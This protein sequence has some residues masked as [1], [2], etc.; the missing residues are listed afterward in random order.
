MS[1][2]ADTRPRRLVLKL[3]TRHDAEVALDLAVALAA[4]LHSEL[5]ALFL[6]EE[7]SIT[8]GMLP[9]PT[10]VDF[11]G[12]TLPS[13]RARIETA[14][15][16][17]AEACRRLLDRAARQ[18][19]L[20]WSFLNIRCELLTVLGDIG[21]AGDI[22]ALRLDPIALTVADAIAI[23]H[24][25]GPAFGGM[26]LLP[27][28]ARRQG[29]PVV[30]LDD[31]GTVGPV[32]ETARQLAKALETSLVRADPGTFGPDWLRLP[33][34]GN[35]RL[36]VAAIEGPLLHDPALARALAGGLRAP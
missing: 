16:R 21:G 20:A 32:T 13:D 4:A 25:L 17:E 2:R 29:G 12:T 6:E 7:S 31:S 27:Q 30:V 23:V 22:L 3:S 14:F 11:T 9:F 18:A 19:E 5:S 8:A 33:P 15:R 1:P 28:R 36:I 26:L 35:A 34:I 24:R 10:L